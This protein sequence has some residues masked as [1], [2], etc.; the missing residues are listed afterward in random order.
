MRGDISPLPHTFSWLGAEWNSETVL[1]FNS[2]IQNL[3]RI[4]F[5]TPY[6]VGT[7]VHHRQLVT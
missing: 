2:Q 5:Y 3:R 1:P 7:E 6:T 4:R